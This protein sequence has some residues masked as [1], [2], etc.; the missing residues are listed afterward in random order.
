MK[1]IPLTQGKVAIID[2]EDFER[3]AA[4]KWQAAK[5]GNITYAV[6]FIGHRPLRV[7][8]KMHRLIMG[9][10]NPKIL[11]DHKNGNG[12]DNQKQNLHVVSQSFN[13]RQTGKQCMKRGLQ[14]SSQY[15]GICWV[16]SLKYWKASMRFNGQRFHCGYYNDEISAARAYDRKV[17]ELIGL[18]QSLI[19]RILNFKNEWIGVTQ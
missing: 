5:N 12:C 8:V 10:T 11:I 16:K 17:V 9:V 6:A 4:H 3:V 2:D 1:E 15:K 7:Q 13:L 14:P 18:K 19:G